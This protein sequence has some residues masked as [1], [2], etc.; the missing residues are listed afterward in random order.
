M[1]FALFFFIFYYFFKANHK[2][3]LKTVKMA[4]YHTQNKHTL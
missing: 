3:M 4:I 1:Q 2:Q